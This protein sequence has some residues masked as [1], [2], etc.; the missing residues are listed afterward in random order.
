MSDT[1]C[2]RC[3]GTNGQHSPVHTRY[4]NGGGGNKP[5]PNAPMTLDRARAIGANPFR[6]SSAVLDA[7]I[8]MLTSQGNDESDEHLIEAIL[9]EV[10]KREDVEPPYDTPSLGDRGIDLPTYGA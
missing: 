2:S 5:C 10:S 8:D 9:D 4:G 6:K 3:G 7:A 1:I